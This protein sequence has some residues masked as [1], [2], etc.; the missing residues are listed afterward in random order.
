M[1]KIISILF[2][3]ILMLLVFP[4]NAKAF[5]YDIST[6]P[7]TTQYDSYLYDDYNI[8]PEI[9]LNGV[10]ADLTD[11]SSYVSDSISRRYL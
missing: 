4:N 9:Y 6:Y 10:R 3:A 2:F 7:F 8:K 1:R 11:V 5:S